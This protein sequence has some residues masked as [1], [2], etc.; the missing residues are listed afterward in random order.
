[1]DEYVSARL[2]YHYDRKLLDNVAFIH[3]FEYLPDLEDVSQF[4]INADAGLRVDISK[5]M[6]SEF[7]AQWTHNSMPPA[8]T[9]QNDFRYLAS[10]GWHF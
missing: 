1:V 2:A 7:K 3:N 10:V 4:V 6:F 8:G 9:L 5:S